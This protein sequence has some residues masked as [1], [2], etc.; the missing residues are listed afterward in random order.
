MITGKRGQA[1]RTIL[2]FGIVIISLI[3]VISFWDVL[4][5]ITSDFVAANPSSPFTNILVQLIPVLI[6]IFLILLIFI[7]NEVNIFEG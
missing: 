1:V 6:P 2:V 4:T 7:P 3:V 5:S